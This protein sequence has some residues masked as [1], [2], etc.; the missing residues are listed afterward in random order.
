MEESNKKCRLCDDPD[1]DRLLPGCF[2]RVCAL[3]LE[4]ILQ[5]T[6]QAT[7]KSPVL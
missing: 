3:C 1:A 4:D 6:S 7:C 2:H 5:D